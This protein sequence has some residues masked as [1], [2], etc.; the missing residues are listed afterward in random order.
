M[1]TNDYAVKYTLSASTNNEFK[2]VTIGTSADAASYAKAFYFDDINIFESCFILLLNR[3]NKT[4]GYAKISQGGIVSTVVDVKIIAKYAVDAMASG[5]ILIHNHPSGNLT[6]SASDIQIAGRLK[7]AL[8]IL[9][10][11]LLDSIILT[12]NGYYS[13]LDNGKL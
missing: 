5:V 10:I 11:E 4:T 3:A 2:K 8:E 7:K 6:P 1:D 12:D 9:E 13:L